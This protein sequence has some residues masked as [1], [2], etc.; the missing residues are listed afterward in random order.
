M[1]KLTVCFVLLAAFVASASLCYGQTVTFKN[2]TQKEIVLILSRYVAKT[3]ER[4]VFGYEKL[5]PGQAIPYSRYD[6]DVFFCISNR[7][8][9]AEFRSFDHAY[10]WVHETENFITRADGL[11]YVPR[12]LSDD[13][14]NAAL[15][16]KP[17]NIRWGRKDGQDSY[18][19]YHPL[20]MVFKTNDLLKDY[21]FVVAKFYKAPPADPGQTDTR[22]TIYSSHFDE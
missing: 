14:Y 9:V 21:G 20:P 1:K 4:V 15:G 6:G 5:Q 8:K 19:D 3:N 2:G 16:T 17:K 7:S 18:S 12:P 10:F 11:K 13:K 22:I